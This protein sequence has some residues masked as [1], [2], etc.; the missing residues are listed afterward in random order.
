MEH[1]TVAKGTHNIGPNDG[2][3][4]VNVYKEGPG[5]AKMGHDLTLEASSW[6]GTADLNPD[7]PS[8]SSVSVT[9]DPDSLE[10]AEAKGGGKPLSQ[11][12]K[13]DIKKNAAKVLGR[14]DIT[15]ESTGVSGS[16]PSLQ[17]KGNLT[18]GG[19]TRPVTLNVNVDDSG[20]VTGTT[21]FTHK[22]FGLKPFSAPL[23]ILKVKDGVDISIDLQLPTA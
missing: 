19:Q 7:D 2:K 14:S 3:V 22:E 18:L 5:A 8:S 10:I 9:I 12:D 17:L 23:G 1:M 15:F 21:S 13:A 16:A 4:L 20:H 11:G 6:N